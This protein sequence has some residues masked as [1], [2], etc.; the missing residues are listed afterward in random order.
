MQDSYQTLWRNLGLDCHCFL[1]KSLAHQNLNIHGRN[2]KV[3][4]ISERSPFINLG[5]FV[6]TQINIEAVGG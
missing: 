2:I 5:I 6:S 4:S 1:I 3:A